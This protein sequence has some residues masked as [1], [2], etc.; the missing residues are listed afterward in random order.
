MTLPAVAGVA[1]QDSVIR[2]R[3]QMV[4]SHQI[5]RRYPSIRRVLDLQ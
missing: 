4:P 2:S 5:D 1:H 3:A